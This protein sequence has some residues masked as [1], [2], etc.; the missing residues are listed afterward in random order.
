M[1]HKTR[2]LF[3]AFIIASLFLEVRPAKAC[4]CLNTP[5]VL[6]EYEWA[7]NIVVVRALSVE[8]SERGV[9]GIASTRTLVERV[10]KGNLKAGDEMVFAQGGGSDCTWTFQE[11]DIGRQLLFYLSRK[12]GDERLWYAGICGRS[13]RL[14]YAA[15]DLLYLENIDKVRG[16]TRLSGRLEYSQAPVLEGEQWIS[17]PLDGRKVR[18]IGEKKTYE[19][20]TN[21]QGVYEIYDLPAGMY[22]IETEAI[23]GWKVDDTHASNRPELSRADRAIPAKLTKQRFQVIVEA[24][25]HAFFDLGYRIDNVIRGKV[26]DVAGK[27]LNDVCLRLV[28]TQG[29]ASIFLEGSAYTDRYGRFEIKSVAPGSYF[30]AVKGCKQSA[31]GEPSEL[32]YYPNVSEREKAGVITI[33]AGDVLQDINIYGLKLPEH[34]E[35]VAA[36]VKEFITVKG[37]V[38]YENGEAAIV[39]MVEFK[40]DDADEGA[41]AITYAYTDSKGRFSVSIPKGLKGKLYSRMAAY[42]GRF[43]N[44]PKF[45]E[46][47]RKTVKNIGEVSTDAVEIGGDRNLSGIELKYPFPRCKIAR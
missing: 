22:T 40:A 30:I 29:K 17:R 42:A 37:T 8:K 6:S 41:E 23:A 36:K 39:E 11:K 27:G 2:F 16:K 34:T 4:S 21:H 18:I 15:D 26:F 32:F 9:D 38:T 31:D 10:F 33:D 24:G 5:T 20:F 25:K 1:L 14:E 28:P 46:L 43:E 19:R 3:F 13:A 12:V 35:P 45:D 44:C 7:T 47:V